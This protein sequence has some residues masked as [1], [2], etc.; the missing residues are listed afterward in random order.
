MMADAIGS[1]GSVDV[2]LHGLR[3]AL[4]QGQAAAALVTQ[5]TR[6]LKEAN[7]AP[8]GN[9]NLGRVLDMRA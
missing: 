2:A 9:P 7:A 5:A 1:A 8:A 6:Q 3:L 4:Q